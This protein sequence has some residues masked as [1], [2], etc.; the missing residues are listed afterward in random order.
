MKK[1]ANQTQPL[2]EENLTVEQQRGIAS[3]QGYLNRSELR[4]SQNMGKKTHNTS[5][6]NIFQFV[7]FGRPAYHSPMPDDQKRRKLK[8]WQKTKK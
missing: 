6:K 2:P 5:L 3:N 7:M 4:K 1:V 8:Y